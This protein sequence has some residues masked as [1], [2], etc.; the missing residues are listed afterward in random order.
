M[1]ADARAEGGAEPPAAPGR[2]RSRLLEIVALVVLV[3]P[4][5][6]LLPGIV[7]VAL[8][9]IW[10]GGEKLLGILLAVA[11]A[12]LAFMAWN[13]GTGGDSSGGA[14]EIGSTP[15]PAEPIPEDDDSSNGVLM[16]A[17]FLFTFLQGLPSVIFLGWRLRART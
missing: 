14:V 9:R 17:A 11:P 12:V 10:S 8:S 5:A 13:V 3:V 16:V 6:G 4:A 15:F 2:P 1:P 7:L